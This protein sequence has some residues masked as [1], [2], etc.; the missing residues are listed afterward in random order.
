[1]RALT[2]LGEVGIGDPLLEINAEVMGS[3]QNICEWND[4]PERTHDEF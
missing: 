2:E 4:S 3:D 1:M